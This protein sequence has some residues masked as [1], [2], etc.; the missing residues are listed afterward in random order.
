MTAETGAMPQIRAA[1]DP[2]AKGGEFYAPRF[3]NSGAAVRRPILRRVGLTKA[4]A[5]LWTVSE[6][7]TGLAMNVQ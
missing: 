3:I 4:I 6:R 2:D 7:E 5:T 1:T